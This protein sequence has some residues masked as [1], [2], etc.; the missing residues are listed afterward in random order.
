MLL[1]AV[2]SLAGAQQQR[3][4]AAQ[5]I[6]ADQRAPKGMC[7]IWL[8]D[9]PPA[10]Q[11]AAT[12]C[13]AAVKNCPPNGRV[14][15]GDTEDLKTRPKTDAGETTS[16]RKSPPMTKGFVGKKSDPLTNPPILRKPPL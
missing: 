3:K 2:A 16:S 5:E 1:V 4:Q 11:P 6:P 10:Q 14:I 12:D 7:R 13:A 9:I 8:R 15:F